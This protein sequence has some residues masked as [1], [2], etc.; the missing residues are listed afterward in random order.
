MIEPNTEIK[1]EY[2]SSGNLFFSVW[3]R[4]HTQQGIALMKELPE[5]VAGALEKA[6]QPFLTKG[7]NNDNSA[8]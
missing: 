8:P 6:L 1:I 5:D 3:H 2:T 7:A 4:V